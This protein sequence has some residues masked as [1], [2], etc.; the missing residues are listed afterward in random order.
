MAHMRRGTDLALVDARVP[1][2]RVLYLQRPVFAVRVVYRTESLVGR[3]RVPT[4]SQEM[5]VAMAHPRH[6]KQHLQN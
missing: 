6:L 2:L 4:H 1:M 5:D 3:V